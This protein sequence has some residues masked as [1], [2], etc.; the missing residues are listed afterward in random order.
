MP[1]EASHPFTWPALRGGG[2]AESGWGCV[3]QGGSAPLPPQERWWWHQGGEC[4]PP[5]V[6]YG[7]LI[8]VY[9]QSLPFQDDAGGTCLVVSLNA[10]VSAFSAVLAAAVSCEFL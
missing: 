8:T 5:H 9:M 1:M 4:H 3:G 7:N 6:N 2:R 10:I